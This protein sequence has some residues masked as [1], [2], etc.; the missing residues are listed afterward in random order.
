[1]FAWLLENHLLFTAA[2]DSEAGE[3]TLSDGKTCDTYSVVSC[4]VFVSLCL[5]LSD[6][7]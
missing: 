4:I 3:W 5:I 6:L 7:K 2:T 1:M